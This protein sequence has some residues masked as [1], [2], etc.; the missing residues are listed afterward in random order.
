MFGSQNGLGSSL[1][2]VGCGFLGEM[3]IEGGFFDRKAGGALLTSEGKA[4][5]KDFEHVHVDEMIKLMREGVDERE[6]DRIEKS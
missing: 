1:G 4:R 5:K 2:R 3:S 6:M